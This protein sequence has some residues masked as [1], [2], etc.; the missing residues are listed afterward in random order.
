LNG[1]NV[2]ARRVGA[3]IVIDRAVANDL[4]LGQQVAALRAPGDVIGQ[5]SA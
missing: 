1:L 3:Q 5:T 4:E 2:K